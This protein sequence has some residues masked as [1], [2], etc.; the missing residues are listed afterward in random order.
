M[1]QNKFRVLIKHCFLMGKNTVQAQQWLEKCYRENSLSKT[2]CRLSADFKRGRTNTEDAERPGRSTEV[3]T[4]ENSKKILKIILSDRKV[5]LQE[6]ADILKISKST[7]FKVVHENLSMKKLY[8]KW[9]PRLLTAEQKENR[10]HVSER[11]LKLFTRNKKDF[12]SRYMTM[13]ETWIHQ[14]T[15]ESKRASPDCRGKG[16]SRPKRPKTQQSA[17]KVMASVF[18]DMHRILIID[19]LP[20][21]Q[22]INSDYYVALL[23]R[24]EDAIKKK[25]PHMAKKK[26]L[27]QQDN[28]PVH[29]SMKT[30]VKLNDLRF[31]L[32]PHPPYSPDLAPSDFYLFAA[33]KQMLQGKRFSSDDEVIAATETY[34]EAENKSFFKKG[35]KSLEKRWN[36]C[37][38]MEGDYVDE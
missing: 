22:T 25:R 36:E 4:P 10:I 26:L 5:K 30:M 24:L 17:G 3:A 27:F 15:P 7:V 29:K 33:L 11:C 34:F 35:I 6:I 32:L 38:A 21:G 16:E 1:N 31:E 2:I 20:K 13:N 9:V 8:S 12:L 14:F 23:D 28:A 37:I 18:W 19:F